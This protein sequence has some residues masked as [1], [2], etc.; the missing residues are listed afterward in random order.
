M[1]N[2]YQHIIHGDGV[3][4]SACKLASVHLFLFLFSPLDLLYV[5]Y[6]A[7]MSFENL[8]WSQLCRHCRHLFSS[9]SDP[10]PY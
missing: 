7:L 10:F 9:F 6:K 2:Y 3:Y 5:Q 4:G 1:L 8:E